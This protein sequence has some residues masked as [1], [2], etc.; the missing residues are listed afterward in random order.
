M[1]AGAAHLQGV[2]GQTVPW[3]SHMQIMC[4]TQ[5]FA[6][7]EY[8]VLYCIAYTVEYMLYCI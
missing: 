8:S 6:V 7:G 1:G 3:V 5:G 2:R 4:G